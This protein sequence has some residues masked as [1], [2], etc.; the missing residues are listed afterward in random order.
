MSWVNGK[1]VSCSQQHNASGDHGSVTYHRLDVDSNGV[2]EDSDRILSQPQ[3]PCY[4]P[5]YAYNSVPG[6]RRAGVDH[7]DD[8]CDPD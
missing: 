5:G 8:Q 3:H 1:K 7:R 2:D 6:Q 4:D